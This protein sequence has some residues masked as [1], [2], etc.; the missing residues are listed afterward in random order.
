MPKLPKGRID[1]EAAF[2]AAFDAEI[3]DKSLVGA[4]SIDVTDGKDGWVCFATLLPLRP[5]NTRREKFEKVGDAIKFAL[6]RGRSMANEYNSQ[7]GRT[8]NEVVEAP[9][10][11]IT[12]QEAAVLLGIQDARV[13]RLLIDGRIPGAKRFG[14]A[15]LVPL[16]PEGKPVV[17]QATR[18][19]AAQYARSTGATETGE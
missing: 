10:G 18:G 14:K 9:G 15:W 2:R 17:T 7:E 6:D 8:P 5:W 12:A 16:G 13:R 1:V 3:E 4:G 19:P 11:F